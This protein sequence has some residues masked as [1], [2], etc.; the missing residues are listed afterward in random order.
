MK[1][2][3]VDPRTDARWQRLAYR[4]DSSVFHSP[5]WLQVLADSY[6]LEILA[7]ILIDEMGEA[8]AGIP[9]GRVSDIRGKRLV[10][11]PF[12]DY[13]DPLVADES[14]WRC[15]IDPLLAEG[16]PLSLR[17]LHNHLP[18]TDER[19]AEVGR[20]KWHGLDLRGDKD[21]LWQG[22]GGS[23]RNK[24]RKALRNG[25]GARAARTREELRAFFELHL[26]TRKQKYSLLAQPYRFFENIWRRFVERGKGLLLLAT[27]QNSII[28]GSFFLEWQNKL[29]YKFNASSPELTSPGANDLL[30]WEGIVYSIGKGLRHLDFGLS[31]RDQEGLLRYKRKFASEEKDISFLKCD[32]G[33]IP[34]EQARQF[35]ELL[36]KLTE[37]FTDDAVS[38]R[39]TEKAGEI[40]YRFFC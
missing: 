4:H 26:K 38:E 12:S 35:Q 23:A 11:L 25:V 18:M 8:K 22:L 14:Y 1:T 19:F 2:V 16:C 3:V 6:E 24:I 29:Y 5:E 33:T 27:H 7:N 20:A 13:C 40:L 30:I 21:S 28:A 32:N 15:L 31:D 17:C 10:A 39:V 37:L 36:P 9:F 34:T